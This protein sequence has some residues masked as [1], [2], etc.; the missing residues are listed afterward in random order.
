MSGRSH[1]PRPTENQAIARAD[2]RFAEAAPVP[3]LFACLI[4]AY[5]VQDRHG[6]RLFARA[7]ARRGE[8]S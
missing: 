2:R 6:M 5:A 8:A 4:A 1:I 3:V 7:I